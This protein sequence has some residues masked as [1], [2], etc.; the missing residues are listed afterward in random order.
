MVC[1]YLLST[2]FQLVLA[3][4]MALQLIK[5]KVLVPDFKS[6]FQEAAGQT[7]LVLNADGF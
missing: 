6:L 2:A 3:C 5:Y 7:P 1:W 4:C